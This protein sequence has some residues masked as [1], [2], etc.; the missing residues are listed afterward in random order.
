MGFNPVPADSNTICLY[1]A[2]LARSL[3][4]SSINYSGVI[5]LLHKEF[6]LPNPLTDNWVLKSLLTGI[7]RVKGNLVQQKLPITLDILFRIH[8]IIH[9]NSS[10]DA[11]FWA[12]C[13]IAFFVFFFRKSNLLPLSDKHYDHHKQFSRSSFTLF[14]WGVLVSVLWSKTIQFRERSIHIPF[15]RMPGSPLCPVASLFHAMSFTRSS[16]PSSHAFAHFDPSHRAIRCRHIDLLL[17]S[18]GIVYLG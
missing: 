18:L 3:K 8:S 1:A 12:A 2:F 9:F 17:P 13:L 15:P 14:H 6:G 11:S 7:K 16:A 4:F 5:A 10:F